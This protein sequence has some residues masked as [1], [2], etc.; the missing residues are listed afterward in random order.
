MT[1]NR[2]WLN[3]I[4]EEIIEPDMPIVDPHH[5]FWRT[6]NW[7]RYLL[8]DL[9]A[10][11]NDGPG[12]TSH[13]IIKTVFIECG[14][15]YL[16]SGPQHMRPVG[17]TIFVE[18]IATAARSQ[19]EQ[20]QI[21]GIVNFADMTRGEA[22]EE[23]LVA[24]LEAGNG[25]F[26][27]IRHHASRDDSDDVPNSRINPPADLY[28][29]ATFRAGLKKLGEME[30]TFEAWLYHPQLPQL[31]ALAQAVP[32]T[33]IILNHLGGVLGIGPYA[34]KRDE[35]FV[36][37]QESIRQLSQCE[38]VVVKLGGL[39]QGVNGY[40][41][42]TRDLPPTSDE[43]AEAQRPWHLHALECF[44]ANRCMFESN[45]PVEAMSVSYHVW[46]NTC[47]KIAAGL[48]NAEKWA[49]FVGTAT[50]VYQI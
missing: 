3:Q 35:I 23:V 49:L 50:R 45:Y 15:E 16:T 12:D 36:T 33:T 20:A 2:A 28:D 26:R 18:E 38:N 48:S 29:R 42:E 30:L 27:G 24:Q 37:W 40:G 39:A 11:T 10:D 41:W 21:A 32:E 13:N 7:G 34:G 43:L 5:H 22:V 9:W 4:Q 14:A 44:G 19:P 6:G 25:L 17:E 1:I 46:W 31:I 47:K 8:D